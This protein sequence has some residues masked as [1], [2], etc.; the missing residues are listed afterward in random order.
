MLQIILKHK[1][2]QPLTEQRAI[3]VVHHQRYGMARLVLVHPVHQ[4]MRMPA[5]VLVIVEKQIK[6]VCVRHHCI[7][8]VLHIV[9]TEIQRQVAHLLHVGIRQQ[10]VS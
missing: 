9:K 1:L 8:R 2:V 10:Q 4:P 6:M 7:Q 5:R 3:N